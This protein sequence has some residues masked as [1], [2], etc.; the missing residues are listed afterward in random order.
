MSITYAQ[1]NNANRAIALVLYILRQQERLAPPVHVTEM[2]DAF[3]LT[4]E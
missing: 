4:P 2:L 3:P 1:I